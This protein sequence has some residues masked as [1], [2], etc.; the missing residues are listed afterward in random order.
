M[1][2]CSHG[3][4]CI[5]T[6]C[7]KVI[8][9]TVAK[10]RQHCRDLK[11]MI[12]G[13][14]LND[15]MENADCC[16]LHLQVKP[17]TSCSPHHVYVNYNTECKPLSRLLSH[18]PKPGQSYFVLR[19]L[20]TLHD[21]NKNHD[22]VENSIGQRSYLLHLIWPYLMPSMPN[23]LQHFIIQISVTWLKQNQN[24]L[25]VCPVSSEVQ[26]AIP[27]IRRPARQP[28]L[29][30]L[31]FD[32]SHTSLA[33]NWQVFLCRIWHFFL[34]D[35]FLCWS[36]IAGQSSSCRMKSKRWQKASVAATFNVKLKN[37]ENPFHGSCQPFLDLMKSMP[38]K[39]QHIDH[40]GKNIESCY[41]NWDPPP[42][43]PLYDV[44]NLIFMEV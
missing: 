8:V 42:L 27:K 28:K 31:W 35:N 21:I 17:P 20:N 38:S 3:K 32:V 37:G 4:T 34:T 24:A 10:C 2:S 36:S 6:V 1:H 41:A 29:L 30:R 11:S 44:Q 16:V 23:V 7:A 40:S 15:K 18:L 39:I 22:K 33:M 19:R 13:L 9:H 43:H 14:V 5:V 12:Y 26:Y 25:S